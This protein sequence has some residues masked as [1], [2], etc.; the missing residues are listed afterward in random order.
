M[1]KRA[2]LYCRISLKDPNIPKVEQQEDICRGMAKANGMEVVAL[3]VDDGIGA[4]HFSD[5]DR[6]E[7]IRMLDDIKT[8]AV[9]VILAQAEDR[10]SREPLE[11]AVL[12][13]LCAQNGVTYL[14]HADGPTDPSKASGKLGSG[15]KALVARHY[16][17]TSSEKHRDSNRAAAYRGEPA[18]GGDR[19]F[20]WE[21]DKCAINP[22]EADVI[23]RAF[24]DLISG[25]RTISRIRTDLNNA[26][27]LTSRGGGWDTIKVEAMLRRPRNAGIVVY[28]GKPIFNEDGSPVQA[29]WE[30]IVTEDDYA[31]AMAILDSPKRRAT[32]VYEPKYLCSSIATCGACGGRLRSTSN[33]RAT[34]Y[35]CAS[36]VGVRPEKVTGKHVSISTHILDAAVTDAVV[37]AIMFA[38]S[39]AVPDADTKTLNELHLRQ[40]KVMRTKARLSALLDDDDFDPADFKAKSMALDL[41]LRNI[42]SAIAEIASRNAR[43]ALLVDVQQ[44]LWA[45]GHPSFEKAAEAKQQIRAKFDTLDLARKKALVRGLMT[46]EVTNGRGQDRVNITHLVADLNSLDSIPA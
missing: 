14:T 36:H 17:D 12:D 44:S 37:S 39:D 22:A 2:G 23:G 45:G 1:T 38:P 11:K 19:P 20:G 28:Q 31:A 15:I 46:V 42:E 29:Q 10:F 6:H 8:G 5:K 24:K 9:D 30:A 4:S 7:W 27:V 18:R 35:R 32:R 21:A 34:T 33:A 3:Y 25:E 13:D 26:D 41:E 16:V 40:A 43:A